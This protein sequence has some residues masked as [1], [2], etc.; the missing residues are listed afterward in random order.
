M[1][2]ESGRDRTDPPFAKAAQELRPDS[3]RYLRAADFLTSDETLA[4]GG[5]AAGG[6]RCAASSP[7]ALDPREG[8]P[9]VR[10]EA[11][12]VVKGT[13][14]DRFHGIL[15]RLRIRSP[16]NRIGG[17]ILAGAVAGVG[18]MPNIQSAA[19]PGDHRRHELCRG[20]RTKIRRAFVA[21]IAVGLTI[22]AGLIALNLTA[23]EKQVEQPLARLYDTADPQFARAM[24]VLLGPPIVEGNRFEVLL[25]GD[26]IFPSMLSAIRGAQKTITFESYIYWS[27]AIGQ[28]VRRRALGAGA[29]RRE[30]ARAPRLARQQ[31]ARLRPAR[32]DG[33][34]RRERPQVPRAGLVSPRPD[35]QPHAPQGAGRR[36]QGGLHRRCRHRRRLER[37]CPGSRALAR[38]ALSRRRAGRGA[39]AGGIHGQL[40]QGDRRRAARRRLL[41]AAGASAATARRRCSAARRKA[42]ARACISCICWRSPRPRSPS[43]CRAPTSFRTTSRGRR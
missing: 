6:P 20:G 15:T 39:N 11:R 31:Q 9:Q 1:P 28:R 7:F 10:L 12:R 35:E 37:Q 21:A 38:H 33:R 36:R 18:A 2:G 43:T 30:S 34:C 22:A 29:G 26:E 24:G 16:A 3:R 23:G 8:L 13:I 32:D 41:S 40:D 25:N 27:G 19:H 17:A 4:S 42:A 5:R 14:Q